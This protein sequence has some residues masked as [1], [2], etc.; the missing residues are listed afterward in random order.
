M[1]E[2]HINFLVIKCAYY[3]VW[4]RDREQKHTYVN[5][6]YESYTKEGTKAANNN[7]EE[8]N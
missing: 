5:Q 8:N 2:H 4:L 6:K 3:Y 1:Q 7:K